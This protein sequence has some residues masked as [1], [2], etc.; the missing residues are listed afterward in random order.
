MRTVINP[1]L[2]SIRSREVVFLFA[3]LLIAG[4]FLVATDAESRGSF[5]GSVVADSL[6]FPGEVFV[7]SSDELADRRI[8]SLEDILDLIPGVSYSRSG[9]TGSALYISVEGR[10]MTGVQLLLNGHPFSDPWDGRPLARFIPMSRLRQVEIIYSSSP[11]ITGRSGSGSVINL[12]IEEGGRKGPLAVGDFSNGRGNR[13]SR[14]FW[15]STPESFINLTVAYDEYLQDASEAIVSEPGYLIGQYNSRSF[16]SELRIIT[17][18]DES[19][20]LHIQRYEDTYRGTSNVP[21]LPGESDS[22]EDIRY[23][24]VDSRIELRKNGLELSVGQRLVEMKR[25]TG[26]TSGLVL[27]AGGRWHISSGGLDL[28]MFL[29]GERVA[30]ENR[31]SGSYFGPEYSDLRGGI[32]AGGDAGGAGIRWRGGI[33]SGHHDRVGYWTGGEAG[34]TRGS[35]DGFYQKVML[36][37]RLTLPVAEQLFHPAVDPGLSGTEPA[38]AGNPDLTAGVMDEISAGVGFYGKLSLDLF[39][40]R[41]R[42]RSFYSEED[43]LVWNSG[44]ESEV[45]GGRLKYSDNGSRFGIDYGYLLSAEYF[46]NRSKFTYGVPEY[47]LLGGIFLK[48][49]SFKDTETITLRMDSVANG[50]RDWPGA[51]LG[52]YTVHNL[53]FSC[54]VMS[55]VIHLQY[56][57]I[58]DTRYETIPGYFMDRRHYRFGFIWYIFD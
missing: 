57:N 4:V 14:R 29:T 39:A 22:G 40:R 6:A 36:S 1:G 33:Y 13:R 9:P 15:F 47:R 51:T 46:S 19:L 32:S 23:S 41:E 30:F 49:L 55:A 54:T 31:V 34:L 58:F 10:P 48:R 17:D 5:H 3:A 44:G 12:I 24:G 50:E 20:L 35:P 16:M 37:R 52:R 45:A 38:I 43:P 8:N 25:N 53:S 27:S 28:R 42:E 21:A 7:I 2:F 11:A 26:I 18:N 56:N